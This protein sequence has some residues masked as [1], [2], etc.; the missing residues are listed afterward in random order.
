MDELT[1]E[2]KGS[3][4]RRFEVITGAGRR[5]RWALEVKARIVAESFTSGLAVSE[6]ARRHGLRAW[7]LF[8][9]RHAA[10]RGQL[11]APRE[12]VAGFLPIVATR[13]GQGDAAAGSNEIE[14]GG[15]VIRVRGRVAA[16]ALG[17]VLAAVKSIA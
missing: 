6:V 4:L 5:R 14:L 11:G 3:D 7:Q 9:W 13:A 12:E 10:R 8:G 15:L 1:P 17:E 2:P 16:A